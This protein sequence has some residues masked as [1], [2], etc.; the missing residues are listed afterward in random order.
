MNLSTIALLFVV[1]QLLGNKK[2]SSVSSNVR[3]DNFLNDET[4]S[5]ID[6][7]TKISSKEATQED[8]MAAI[9]TAL[10]NPNVISLV[11][12]LTKQFAADKRKNTPP[13]NEEG[14]VFN[15]PSNESQ[16][17]FKPIENIADAEVKN[18]LYSIFDNWYVKR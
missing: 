3:L 15:S 11:D 5:L 7:V 9:F 8:K 13:Q 6:C 16:E 18:K 14:Y 2:N 4:K 1:W 17:F 12:M 10:S